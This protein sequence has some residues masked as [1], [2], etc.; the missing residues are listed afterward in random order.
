SYRLLC[1]EARYHRGAGDVLVTASIKHVAFSAWLTAAAR[2]ANGRF[3][4][5]GSMSERNVL[6][7]RPPPFSRKLRP[8][9]RMGGV[10]HA[11]DLEDVRPIVSLTSAQRA[12]N[13]L[14]EIV[15]GR[16]HGA[17]RNRHGDERPV[18]RGVRDL[19]DEGLSHS[20]PGVHV[21]LKIS[22][23]LTGM[24]LGS[25]PREITLGSDRR[26]AGLRGRRLALAGDDP[27]GDAVEGGLRDDA[28]PDQRTGAPV[29]P[30][31]DDLL[32]VD[33]ADPGKGLELVESGAVDVDSRGL[34]PIRSA[35]RRLG[36]GERNT[37][38]E[39]KPGGHDRSRAYRRAPPVPRRSRGGRR[40]RGGG[41]SKLPETPCRSRSE[42]ANPVDVI[43]RP[44]AGPPHV[45]EVDC[46]S[47]AVVDRLLRG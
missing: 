24:L 46:E 28:F 14:P 7:H 29:R 25:H 12:A 11:G 15:R 5:G 44:P 30:P 45:L 21:D 18:R 20:V 43:G 39:E 32:G 38:N 42:A 41:R 35:S 47:D 40:L 10:Q 31:V 17:A 34:G 9:R 23:L 26:R 37:S 13:P 36:G 22:P 8:E 2:S 6:V 33:V 16:I 3:G 19:D 1:F 27:I 4:E